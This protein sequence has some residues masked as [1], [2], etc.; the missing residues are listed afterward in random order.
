MVG[1]LPDHLLNPN[2]CSQSLWWGSA[3]K[4]NDILVTLQTQL[5]D[6]KVSEGEDFYWHFLAVTQSWVTRS[7]IAR[8]SVLRGERFFIYF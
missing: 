6:T 7:D 8:A 2:L 4:K 3:H 5:G 1:R